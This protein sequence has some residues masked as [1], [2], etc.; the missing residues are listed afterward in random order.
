MA[1]ARGMSVRTS[2]D[3][4]ETCVSSCVETLKTMEP[5]LLKPEVVAQLS[6]GA[7]DRSAFVLGAGEV[8]ATETALTGGKGSSLAILN[9]VAGV[10][11]PTFFCVTTAAYRAH[12]STA[13]SEALLAGLQAPRAGGRIPGLQSAGDAARR[14]PRDRV[15]KANAVQQASIA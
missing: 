11:V 4:H 15:G 7:G 9:A 5:S 6:A 1:L 12:F 14:A 8:L 2:L 10:A 3:T 13:E